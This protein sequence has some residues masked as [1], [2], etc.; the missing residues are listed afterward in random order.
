M[1]RSF[2]ITLI[3]RHP[4]ENPRK[5]SILPLRGRPDILLLRHPVGERP[6]LDGYVRLAAE[7]PE[8]SAADADCGIL[9]LDGSWRWAGAMTRDFL[10]VPPR[11]LKGYRTAYP[12]SSRLGTDPDNGLASVEALFLAYHILGR[13]TEGLLDH[14]HWAEGFLKLNGLGPAGPE[15]P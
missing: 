1:E 13:P 5:C 8:L 14:Y 15:S 7:G 12:R 3:V 2:P 4:K 6:S 11:S 10:D 9:L